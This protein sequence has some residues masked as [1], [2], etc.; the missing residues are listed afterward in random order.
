MPQS[1]RLGQVPTI[2]ICHSDCSFAFSS[3]FGV[4]WVSSVLV[5][6]ILQ[7]SLFSCLL[8]LCVW[9]LSID[10]ILSVRE[11]GSLSDLLEGEHISHVCDCSSWTVSIEV[12]ACS[13]I[14]LYQNV[15]LE[16]L[17]FRWKSGVANLNETLR[18]GWWCFCGWA[19]RWAVLM[20]AKQPSSAEHFPKRLPE[21]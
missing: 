21:N 10:V 20:L 3:A 9:T 13:W 6:L 18:T 14:A 17:P 7:E 4:L 11:I 5:Y 16:P 12:V 19:A 15:F 8:C 1:L 2:V